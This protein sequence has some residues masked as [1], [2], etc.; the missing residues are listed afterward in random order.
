M[1]DSL[2]QIFSQFGL[3]GLVILGMAYY[4][5]TQ[6]TARDLER[7]QHIEAINLMQDRLDRQNE[8]LFG[9]INNNTEKLVEFR[10]SLDKFIESNRK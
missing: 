9:T 10:I 8:L 4:I 6:G 7:K 5:I 3:P 2:L 1:S